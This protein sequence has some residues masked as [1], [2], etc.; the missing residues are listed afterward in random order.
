[1]PCSDETRELRSKEAKERLDRA[2]RAACDLV[3]A[4]H[5]LL[6][7]HNITDQVP[8]TFE[9]YE[10]IK[11]HQRLDDEREVRGA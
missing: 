10:W 9:T 7:K 6:D 8:V 11:E 4:I 5:E 2:T 1:M 3:K